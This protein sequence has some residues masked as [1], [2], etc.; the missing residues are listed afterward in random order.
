VRQTS[1]RFVIVPFVLAAATLVAT[2]ASAQGKAGPERHKW[3][4]S[5]QVK[6]EVGLSDQQSAD[7]EAVFQSFLPRLRAGWEELDRLEQEVSR[8]MSDDTTDE[9][10][11]SAAID[12]AEGARASLNKTRT[13]MLFKMYRVLSPDQRVKLKS[14]H[15]RRTRERQP[16]ASPSGR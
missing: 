12:R 9:A 13:L 5:D 16:G 6:T 1:S 15:D 8:L 10:R 7:L 4:Q 2:G 3:W 11:I 14:F